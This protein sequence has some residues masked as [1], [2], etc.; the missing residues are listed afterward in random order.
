MKV[1]NTMRIDKVLNIFN[2]KKIFW[3]LLA[4][5]AISLVPIL[6]LAGYN[7][8]CADDF[9]ASDTAYFAWRDT[10]SI[11]QVIK[12]AMENVAYNY[13]EWSGVFVSVF[14]T[15]LQPGI[16]GE[17]YYAVTTWI[18]VFLLIAACSYFFKVVL[19][20]YLG[21]DFYD[22][23]I[24]TLV[25]LFSLIQSM[26][27]GLEGLYWHAGVVNYTWAF[28][29][30]LLLTAAVLSVYKEEVK[31]KKAFKIVSAVI[32][33]MLVGGGNYIIALQGCLWY[34]FLLLGFAFYEI[35]VQNKTI[36]EYLSN[37][38]DLIIPYAV[39]LI[40]FGISVTAPGNKVRMGSSS[41]M[42][43]L[44]S[45]IESFR[46]ALQMPAENWFTVPVLLLI[47]AAIPSMVSIGKVKRVAVKNGSLILGL[48]L[49]F[50]LVAAGFTPNL[51]AQGEMVAGRLHN[52]VFFVWLLIL[53]LQILL[54][55]LWLTG[56][57]K[58]SYK[59]NKSKSEGIQSAILLVCFI[60]FSVLSCLDNV[61]TYVGT[62]A[63]YSLI[64]GEAKQYEMENKARLERLSDPM[65]EDVRLDRFQ[66]TPY[67]LLFQDL[68]PDPN[69][70]VNTVVAEYY[71]K[72]SV[73]A[74]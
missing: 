10:G 14:W 13:R 69:E 2:K 6:L 19:G 21:A 9:S 33:A 17:E 68:S 73:T 37:S 27:S 25:F 42:G 20:K 59:K 31:W 70:W 11:F 15:S 49:G 23:G 39:L 5:V 36:K 54:L 28:G 55:T 30:L 48:V 35:K 34:T 24:I 26:P 53:Y 45:I 72:K 44:E 63:L 50:C 7:Y 52:T 67:L 32:L 18:T 66:A 29:F 71:E 3:L 38:P 1:E 4:L 57:E 62:E 22:R 51:Y 16:F 65:V 43:I 61:K 47:L 64:S 12:A 8:P 41:G 60:V 40:S 46:Y 74:R 58:K 56:K